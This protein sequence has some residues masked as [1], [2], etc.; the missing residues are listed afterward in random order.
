MDT[1]TRTDL[2]DTM[3][4]LTTLSQDIAMLEQDI[5]ELKDRE[6]TLLESLRI[7][8]TPATEPDL[9]YDRDD[10]RDDDKD[11]ESYERGVQTGSRLSV[12]GVRGRLRLMT[13]YEQTAIP[14]DDVH[15]PHVVSRVSPQGGWVWLKDVEVMLDELDRIWETR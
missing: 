4:R 13:R 11:D 3:R 7:L 14:S 6:A 1:K 10:D 9:L 5:A 2:Y 15:E 8:L 12:A